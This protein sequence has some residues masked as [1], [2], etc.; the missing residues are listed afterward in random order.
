MGT[1]LSMYIYILYINFYIIYQMGF[2]REQ[3]LEGQDATDSIE[4]RDK[5]GIAESGKQTKR[6]R[7]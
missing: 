2:I 7:T 6:D 4:H 5:A 1:S 3:E